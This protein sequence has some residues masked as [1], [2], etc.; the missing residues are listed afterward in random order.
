MAVSNRAAAGKINIGDVRAG[1]DI[2]T[3]VPTEEEE[4]SKDRTQTYSLLPQN[5][6]PNVITP[7]ANIAKVGVEVGDTLNAQGTAASDVPNVFEDYFKDGSPSLEARGNLPDTVYR[8]P[9]FPDNRVTFPV[10]I[11]PSPPNQIIDD[12]N[13]QYLFG[14]GD[15]VGPDSTYNQWSDDAPN[16]TFN[17]AVA[18]IGTGISDL[19]GFMTTAAPSNIF[20]NMVQNAVQAVT[21][22]NPI[23]LEET[24]PFNRSRDEPAPI[25]YPGQST[26]GV[27]DQPS[28]TTGGGGSAGMSQAD[29]DAAAAAIAEAAAATQAAATGISGVDVS[30]G[31]GSYSPGGTAGTGDASG[32]AGESGIFA[33]G[34]TVK[35]KAKKVPSFMDSK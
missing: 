33:S 23:S 11:V 16:L 12:L 1:L 28:G 30:G 17:E 31:G 6:F 7:S 24:N 22:G 8:V 19:F 26:P 13:N 2:L 3:S 10:P 15:D 35:A 18:G 29:M 20:S 27:F 9:Q 34:G 5:K 14:V 4:D 32:E 21:G 25:E